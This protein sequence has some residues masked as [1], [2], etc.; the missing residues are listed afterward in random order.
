VN[1]EQF[2][3]D[4]VSERTRQFN[5][6][7]TE[8]DVTKGP[9]DWIVTIASLLCEAQTRHGVA[10][11]AEEFYEA[12]TKAAATIHAAVEHIDLMVTKNRLS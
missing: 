8:S 11:T 3:S 12:L 10:P 4:V 7:G 6:P 5:L 2:L 1:V 9:N